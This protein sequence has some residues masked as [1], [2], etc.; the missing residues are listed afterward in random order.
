MARREYDRVEEVRGHKYIRLKSGRLLSYWDARRAAERAESDLT[1]SVSRTFKLAVD[2]DL[3]SLVWFLE[4][5]DDYVHAVLHAIEERRG[6]K[7]K[8]ER[9][10]MLRNTTGRTPEE[11]AAYHR[12]ADE[13]EQRLEAARST[14]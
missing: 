13:L 9:I 8:E 1:R 12:K 10:A 11:A 4:G 5:I 2:Y 14:T 6:V 3:E 7:T